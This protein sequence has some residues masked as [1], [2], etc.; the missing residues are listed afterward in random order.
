MFSFSRT[1]L[2]L[3][4]KELICP[5]SH[6]FR[7]FRLSGESGPSWSEFEASVLA[8]ESV[9]QRIS[10]DTIGGRYTIEGC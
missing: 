7:Y 4:G 9:T 8:A 2:R 10:D 5:R 6:P 1:L 3:R